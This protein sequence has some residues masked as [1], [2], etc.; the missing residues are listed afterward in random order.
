MSD[1]LRDELSKPEYELLTDQ[2]AADAIAAKTVS[3]RRPVATWVVKKTA[4]ESGYYPAIVELSQDQNAAPVIRGLCIGV[5]AWI[6]DQR[7][8]TVDMDLP[9]VSQM[10]SGLVASGICTQPQVEA[11]SDLANHTIPWTESVGLPEIG[12]GLVSAARSSFSG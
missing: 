2:E 8:Q 12:R 6:D 3:V 7:I 9:V 1:P 10:T 11:L 5:L 4:I